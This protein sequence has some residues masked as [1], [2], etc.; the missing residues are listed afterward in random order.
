[1]TWILGSRYSKSLTTDL[2]PLHQPLS[3]D[4][5]SDT[6]ITVSKLSSPK[7]FLQLFLL[8]GIFEEEA[9]HI[10]FDIKWYTPLPRLTFCFHSLISLHDSL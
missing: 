5:G 10:V 6:R 2:T 8:A 1:M 9:Q 3:I 7:T 4:F